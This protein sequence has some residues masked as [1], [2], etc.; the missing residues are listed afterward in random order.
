MDENEFPLVSIVTLIYKKYDKLEETILSV[1]N[2]DYPN[3][4]YIISDDG[5]PDF[6]YEI[7]DSIVKKNNKNGFQIKIFHNSTNRGTVKNANYSYK[8]A[9]GD[10]F[11]NLSSGDK[12]FNTNTIS[13]II[14]RFGRT[15]C[16]V[17]VTSRILYTGEYSPV[18]YLP[19]KEER[20]IIYK[21]NAKE[22]GMYKALIL[23]ELYDAVSGSAMH[24]TRQVLEKF[25]YFD[26]KYILWE[27][28]P[29][30]AKYCYE[31]K[32][33]TA[34]DIISIWYQDGGISR[35]TTINPLLLKDTLKFNEFE[36]L[37]HLDV[38]SR[39]ELKRIRY[40]NERTLANSL[41]KKIHL[42]IR[43]FP[44][45]LHYV[46]MS[47]KRKRYARLDRKNIHNING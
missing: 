19:H 34:Y 46:F 11:I 44:Q 45:M 21:F 41:V 20:E 4:E 1:L 14:D 3:I 36:R 28:G 43:F 27:D 5:S 35:G 17:M 24:C 8:Q 16:D 2:Q 37:E 42:Y 38:F 40:R 7:I 32:I 15:N 12:F 39:Q 29:F 25:N 30:M 10:Y 9:N 31:N 47:I 33:E 6:P 23:G 13:Q 18:C 26:E 22:K